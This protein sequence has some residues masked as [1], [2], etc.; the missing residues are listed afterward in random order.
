[1]LLTFVRGVT[2]VQDGTK[3]LTTECKFCSAVSQ[4]KKTTENTVIST[5]MWDRD[6]ARAEIDSLIVGLV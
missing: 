2:V 6:G 5:S 3:L 4:G 1:M